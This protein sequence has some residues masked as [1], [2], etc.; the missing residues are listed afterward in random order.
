MRKLLVA[1]LALGLV[2]A[3]TAPAFATDASFSGYYR[4]R[5]FWYDNQ[6][7]ADDNMNLPNSSQKAGF[8]PS[9]TWR[10]DSP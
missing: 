1:L 2:F 6:A 3:F 10:R 5:G 7:V 4:L 9:S 8:R